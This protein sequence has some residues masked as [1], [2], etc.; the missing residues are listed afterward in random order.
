[1]KKYLPLIIFVLI[2]ALAAY[3]IPYPLIELKMLTFMG[4]L[5]CN[6]SMLKLFNLGGFV[7]GFQKY[8]AIANRVLV[9]AYFFPFIEL[10]MGLSFLSMKGLAF[11][12]PFTFV[13]LIISAV[14]VIVSL[15]QGLDVKCVCMGTALDIPLST[16]TLVED[17]GMSAMALGLYLKF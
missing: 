9:Y 5:F 15:R 11:T 13:W 10:A 1:M 4:L 2:A 7:E 8:D 6:F 3:A 14:S 16:V 12:L 17:L